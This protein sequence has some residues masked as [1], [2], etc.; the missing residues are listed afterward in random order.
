MID[1]E[2]AVDREDGYYAR[3]RPRDGSG[4]LPPLEIDKQLGGR[5]DAEKPVGQVALM[6]LIKAAYALAES[7]KEVSL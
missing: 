6:R 1:P 7:G 3:V 4:S 2:E 5:C